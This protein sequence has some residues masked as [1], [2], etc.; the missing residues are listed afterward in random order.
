MVHSIPDKEALGYGSLTEKL[1]LLPLLVVAGVG[2][3][4]SL[5][6]F[7]WLMRLQ[8]KEIEQEFRWRAVNHAAVIQRTMDRSLEALES[9]G[10]LFAASQEVERSEFRRF[11][12]GRFAHHPGLQALEWVPQVPDRERAAYEQAAR[13]DGFQG[14]RIT[15][16]EARGHMVPAVRRPEYFPV[17][18]LEPLAG[19]EQALGFDLGSNPVRRE[20]LERSRDSGA[21]VTSGRI[22]LQETTNRYGVLVFHPVYRQGMTLADVG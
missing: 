22:A 21:V 4:L 8:R 12:A 11:T 9:V 1:R 10:A 6:L 18:Y 14:F 15:E 13:A 17:F 5:L 19:N 2:I 16:R 7:S 20:T 3:M